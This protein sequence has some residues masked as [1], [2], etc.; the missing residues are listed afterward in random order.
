MELHSFPQSKMKQELFSV[1]IL[2]PYLNK[3]SRKSTKATKSPYNSVPNGHDIC[4][5]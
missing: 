2:T 1:K 3:N 4:G 5:C